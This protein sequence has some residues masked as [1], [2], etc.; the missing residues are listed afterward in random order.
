MDFVLTNVLI[1]PSSS[2]FGR[3]DLGAGMSTAGNGIKSSAFIILFLPL[4]NTFRTFFGF[5]NC[6][7]FAYTKNKYQKLKF[8]TKRQLLILVESNSQWQVST[9]LE[10]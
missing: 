4:R 9:H 2:F 1:Q 6:S 5:L 3:F 8:I 10:H 7:L